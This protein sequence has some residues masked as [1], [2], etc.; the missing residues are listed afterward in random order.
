MDVFGLLCGMLFWGIV[1]LTWIAYVKHGKPSKH[2]RTVGTGL[3]VMLVS[4]VGLLVFRGLYIEENESQFFNAACQG[5][6][7]QV[8]R[9]ISRGA[10]VNYVEE[11]LH[12]TPLEGATFGGH[13]DTVAVLLRHHPVNTAVALQVA[14]NK[15]YTEIIRLLK[16]AGAK[17]VL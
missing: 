4:A 5:D 10:D 1:I 7:A 6:T 13:K 9:L 11:N 15:G 8:E 16:A 2:V 17:D 14:K 3:L 12:W